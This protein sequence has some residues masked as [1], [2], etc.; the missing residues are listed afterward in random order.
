MYVRR[1]LAAAST[2]GVERTIPTAER[3]ASLDLVTVG[4]MVC[5]SHPIIRAARTRGIGVPPASVAVSMAGAETL[6][7]TVESVV[8]VGSELARK[9]GI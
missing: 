1:D 6:I 2:G 4:S 8:R 9:S 7:S 5:K 3:G